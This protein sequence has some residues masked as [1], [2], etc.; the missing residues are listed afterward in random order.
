MHA[1]QK[2][3]QGTFNHIPYLNRSKCSVTLP[4]VHCFSCKCS[5]LLHPKKTVNSTS[6]YIHHF[7]FV[8]PLH[9][10]PVLYPCQLEDSLICQMWI[11]D[12]IFDFPYLNTVVRRMVHNCYYKLCLPSFYHLV[13]CLC[14]LQPQQPRSMLKNQNDKQ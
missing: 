4:F 5:K 10:Q 12:T 8:W 2:G 1:A 14:R 11:L 6:W 13:C 7:F 3:L 9:K